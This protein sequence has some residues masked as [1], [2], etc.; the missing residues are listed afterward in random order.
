M[1]RVLIVDD[2][3]RMRRVLQILV[4]SSSSPSRPRGAL[5]LQFAQVPVRCSHATV[6]LGAAEV[7]RKS[8]IPTV[9]GEPHF[10]VPTEASAQRPCP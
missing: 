7:P 4:E 1:K 8:A 9:A 6:A 10:R 3:P 2:E 5:S